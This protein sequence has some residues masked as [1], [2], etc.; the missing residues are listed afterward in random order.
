MRAVILFLFFIPVK[1]LACVEVVENT[2]VNEMTYNFY[3]DNGADSCVR[4]PHVRKDFNPQ[5]VHITDK[6][7]A[8]ISMHHKETK[9]PS[10]VVQADAKTGKVLK[11]YQLMG[12]E[13]RGYLGTVRS[14]SLFDKG[15]KFVVPTEKAFCMFDKKNAKR[16]ADGSYKAHLI[17]CQEQGLEG[18]VISSISY[19]PNKNGQ[20]Y[21]WAVGSV[22]SKKT[23]KIFGYKIVGNRILKQPTYKFAVPKSVTQVESLAILN[24]A[25]NKY[26]FLLASSKGLKS[27]N[28][29]EVEYAYD[30]KA[31]TYK[32]KLTS[33]RDIANSR[34]PASVVSSKSSDKLHKNVNLKKSSPKYLRENLPTIHQSVQSMMIKNLPMRPPGE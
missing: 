30:E 10:R 3:A 26:N 18:S 13:H 4:L 15:R 12:S 5:G 19:G 25:P 24:S 29:Y 16:A 1:S 7:I 34:N 23:S 31:K 27:S 14:V 17:A 33:H 2:R 22:S 21:I 9:L 20:K 6:D 28:M 8:Y 11:T 32:P